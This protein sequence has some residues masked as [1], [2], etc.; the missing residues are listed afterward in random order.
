MDAY[1]G[2]NQIRMHPRDKENI[3]FMGGLSNYCYT[4]MSFG[5]KNAGA[6]YQHL[7]D[8]ILSEMLGRNTETYVDDMMV[9]SKE[10][11]TQ[12]EDLMKLFQALDKYKLNLNP[13]KCVF[14]VKAD[15]FLG[16]L[17]T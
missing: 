16:F 4:V 1:S 3:T 6:I 10:A 17:L 2:Y 11:C 8:H 5:L 13:D 15:K 12:V 14:G 9:K 7:M